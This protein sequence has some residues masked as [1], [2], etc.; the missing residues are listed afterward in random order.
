M[1]HSDIVDGREASRLDL[2]IDVFPIEITGGE[3]HQFRIQ[4]NRRGLYSQK[5]LV[6]SRCPIMPAQHLFNGG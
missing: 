5:R 1:D 3:E 6:I 2:I 4:L